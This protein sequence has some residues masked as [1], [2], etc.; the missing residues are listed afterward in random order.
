MASLAVVTPIRVRVEGESSSVVSEFHVGSVGA[1]S[2]RAVPAGSGKLRLTRRGRIVFGGLAT[3]LAAGALAFLASFLAP[4]A[5]AS[6]EVSEQRFPYVQVQ[7]G[8]TLWGIA[9]ELDPAADTRNVVAEI[10][11]LNQLESSDLVAGQSIAIP[12][13]FAGAESAS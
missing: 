8:D 2:P 7:A 5:V 9:A 4:G 12:M 11:R 10:S 6:G 3:V 13:R 1:G